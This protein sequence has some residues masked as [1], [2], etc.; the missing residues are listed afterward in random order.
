[1]DWTGEPYNS[2][3]RTLKAPVTAYL[4]DQHIQEV[5][6]GQLAL[7]DLMRSEYSQYAQTGRKAHLLNDLQRL[8]GRNFADF[9]KKRIEQDTFSDA[10]TYLQPAGVTAALYE[11][12]K[13]IEGEALRTLD[14]NPSLRSQA[15]HVLQ[16]VV[17]SYGEGF[18]E[19][20]GCAV[21]Q[22]GGVAR[23][24]SVLKD[25]EKR[26]PHV[27]K[28]D[29]GRAFPRH[30]TDE[31]SEYETATYFESM[32]LMNYDALVPSIY[33]LWATPAQLAAIRNRLNYPMIAANVM[34]KETGRAVFEPFLLKKM[35]D[36]TVGVIGVAPSV[37][38]FYRD[39]WA[40]EYAT[41]RYEL[42]DP[43][44]TIRQ[45]IGQLRESC[46][47]LIVAGEIPPLSVRRI[48]QAVEGIDVILTSSGYSGF[49]PLDPA[50]P[51]AGYALTDNSGYF[52][53]TLVINSDIRSY[54]LHRVDLTVDKKTGV[55][56]WVLLS[57]WLDGTVRDDDRVRQILNDFY[58]SIEKDARYWASY[59]RRF[60]WALEEQEALNGKN[61]FSGV[62]ACAPCHKEIVDQWRMTLHAQAYNTLVKEHKSFYPRCVI[63]HTTGLNYPTGFQISD[64]DRWL[65]GVQCESCHGPGESH[66]RWAQDTP[67][68]EDSLFGMG[69]V[70]RLWNGKSSDTPE[71]RRIRSVL[72]ERYCVECHDEDNS[73][74]F[75]FAAYW[76]KIKH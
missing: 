3:V 56:Q 23:R 65:S 67:Q 18:L 20:C 66:V 42:L 27:L 25:L 1:V 71:T 16:V 22:S 7:F 33:E 57:K 29:L 61:A 59:D 8:T 37:S 46:D 13:L 26:Y 47:L 62:D 9:W 73:P 39:V 51:S 53:D 63:C 24:A 11:Q 60:F 68:Q 43:I 21:N 45:Y 50:R 64:P 34:E 70:H 5:T 69:Y 54:G 30:V 2:P 36:L 58:A 40:F 49:Y 72:A 75:N 76:E 52:H 55:A 41:A 19:T 74:E 38:D 15:N 4:L 6:K 44:E 28:I 12:R 14:E 31:L 17:S 48:I 10:P 35:G 32:N